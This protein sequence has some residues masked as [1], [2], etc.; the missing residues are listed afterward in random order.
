MLIG[1]AECAHAII[2]LMKFYN[3]TVAE[4]LAA[5]GSSPNG[6]SVTMARRRLRRD[7]L[8]VVKVAGVPLWKRVLQPFANVMV[9]V[10]IVAGCLSLWQGSYID[11]TIIFAIIMASAVIDWVQQYS[12]SRILRSLREREVEQVE[13]IRGGEPLRIS[14]ESLVVGDIFDIYEGQK[15][16]ADARVMCD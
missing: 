5:V 7:G 11:A 13:V 1:D 3:K 2:K 6:L 14:A 16:P 4:T 12:T 15:V 10:L 8:N 9:V